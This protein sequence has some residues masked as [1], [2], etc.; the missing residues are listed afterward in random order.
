MKHSYKKKESI[1][2]A[3]TE[4][5]LAEFR[6]LLNR[7]LPTLQQYIVRRLNMAHATGALSRL[8]LNAEEILD[9]LYIELFERYRERIAD[10]NLETFIYRIVDEILEKQL[11]EK[12]YEKEHF[13]N[14]HQLENRELRDLEE[15]FTIDAEGEFV[16]IDE[17]DDLSSSNKLYGLSWVYL[18]DEDAYLSMENALQEYDKKFVHQE[19]RRQLMKLPETER[20]VFD[21]FWLEE[22]DLDQIAGIRNLSVSDI[23]HILKKVTLTVKEGL[24]QKFNPPAQQW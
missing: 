22:M 23:E 12:S 10:M 11:D 8:E 17:L 6:S 14:L 24:E 4:S 16:M 20:T 1:N 13:V 3:V 15:K 19:I 2:R 18:T 9:I 7:S 21:L 5:D